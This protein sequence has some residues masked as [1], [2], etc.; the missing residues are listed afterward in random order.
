MRSFTIIGAIIAV[1]LAGCTSAKSENTSHAKYTVADGTVI[2]T[3]GKGYSEASGD[4]NSASPPIAS[5]TP[6][7]AHAKGTAPP[8]PAVDTPAQ[9]AARGKVL[10][11]LKRASAFTWLGIVCLIAAIAVCLPIFGGPHIFVAGLLAGAGAFIAF[12]PDWGIVLSPMLAVLAAGILF[13]KYMETRTTRIK[14]AGAAVDAD[15]AGNPALAMAIL[16]TSG[17][18]VSAVAARRAKLKVRAQNAMAGA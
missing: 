1:A 17:P 9:I 4:K 11:M 7:G 15:A 5:V 12:L 16:K 18:T 13:T 6:G 14:A 10:A 8:P 3:W 2:E